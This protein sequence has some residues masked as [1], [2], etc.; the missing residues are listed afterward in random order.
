[1]RGTP[2]T[3]DQRFVSPGCSRPHNEGRLVRYAGLDYNCCY[4]YV[5]DA[6]PIL[7]QAAPAHLGR[8]LVAG[9]GCLVAHTDGRRAAGH[10]VQT[11]GD[12]ARPDARANCS[13]G[14]RITAPGRARYRLGSARCRGAYTLDQH[15]PCPGAGC[16][17][18]VAPAY[19]RQRVDAGCGIGARQGP[20]YG[21]PCLAAARRRLPDRRRRAPAL[22]ADFN[23]CMQHLNSL[24]RSELAQR[25][26]HEQRRT[27]LDRR[28]T[29]Q[30]D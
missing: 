29:G 16:Q 15:V 28:R 3:V 25:S 18:D 21:G 23:V 26:Q 13:N 30:I 12:L 19:H 20:A 22:H 10:P 8:T 14:R 7:A 11:P 4:V 27:G 24:N 17:P 2:V 9:R 1:M 6:N 5:E